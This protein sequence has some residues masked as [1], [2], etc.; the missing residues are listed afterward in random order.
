MR[1]AVKRLAA[2]WGYLRVTRAGTIA[3]T[4]V[5]FTGDGH[6]ARQHWDEVPGIIEQRWRERFGE[7]QIVTLTAA[8]TSLAQTFGRPTPRFPRGA[9]RGT[10]EVPS[11]RAMGPGRVVRL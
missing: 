2:W 9:G 4:R 6:T 11:G 3:D 5:E 7:Q 10:R 8:L 1:R